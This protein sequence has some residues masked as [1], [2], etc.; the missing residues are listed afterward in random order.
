[1]TVGATSILD[2]VRERFD[3]S[4]DFTIGIEEEF[5]ILDPRTMALEN[6]FGELI[7]S[8][9][10][11]FS[12]RLAGELIASEIEFRTSK[13]DTL[14]TAARELAEGRLRTMALAEDLGVCLAISGVHP[15]SRWEEQRIIDTEHYRRVEGELGYVAWTNN[16]WS[17]HLHCGVR[18]ADRAIAVCSAL[19]SLLPDFL[20]LSANSP[21][22]MGRP[23]RLHSTRTQI[24]TKN[25]PRCGVPDAFASWDEY[26]DYV[27]FLE[28]A[29]SI[30]ESTQIWW[31]VRPHHTH[32]TI[33]VRICDGQSEIG[34]AI[35]L[36]ALMLAAIASYCHDFDAGRELPRTEHRFIEE[37]LW[38]AERYGLTGKL[39][40]LTT[41]VERP[42][43]QAIEE[44]LAWSAPAAE[45]IG[46]DR[47][48]GPV[49][50]VLE[51]GNGAI[52][53]LRR[54]DELGGDLQA[55]QAECAER[56]KRSA[57][58]LLE[59]LEGSDG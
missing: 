48:L 14:T 12:Q 15:F 25:F 18:G 35:G 13:H 39:I 2:G 29:N 28:R 1:V 44:L 7:G 55:L 46:V 21:I 6:R 27:S 36:V 38:R 34:E 51:N 24:F 9:R 54:Y 20:A 56:T 4:T 23:T 11:P 59:E 43:V 41:G 57:E 52:R 22:F 26:A 32:G 8:A 50:S 37:N 42:A 53:Q 45:R 19:R 10:E 30:V 3:Q 31:S 33:E 58:E 40:D 17:V 16:T 49:R 5:Q 47:F